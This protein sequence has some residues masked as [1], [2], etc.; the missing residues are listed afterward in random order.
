MEKR[1]HADH[2]RSL[3]IDEAESTKIGGMVKEPSQDSQANM[4]SLQAP[5]S[6]IQ[7][8]SPEQTRANAPITPIQ[9]S[10]C[11][12]S[13]ERQQLTS[14]PLTKEAY[15]TAEETTVSLRRSV[16]TRRPPRRLLYD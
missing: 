16:R 9:T 7:E 6:Q 10:S 2:I 1:R 14:I 4:T 11:E 3:A 5:L 12:L 8:P 15:S 13:Q